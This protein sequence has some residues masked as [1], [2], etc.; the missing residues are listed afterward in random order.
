MQTMFWSWQRSNL[1]G[2]SRDHEVREAIKALEATRPKPLDLP[3]APGWLRE[4]R[5]LRTPEEMEALREELD[6]APELETGDNGDAKAASG[7]AEDWGN[8]MTKPR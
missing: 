3:R 4:D 5:T 2:N 7:T 1:D 8:F 6:E